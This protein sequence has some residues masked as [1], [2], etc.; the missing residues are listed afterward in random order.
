MK[1]LYIG[2]AGMMTNM[3]K[4]NVR[5]NNMANS[6]TS[7]FKFDQM[8]TTPI[9]KKTVMFQDN[10]SRRAIGT[11]EYAV[12]PEETYV[13][14]KPGSTY[15]TGRDQDFFIRDLDPDAGASF[16]VTELRGQ[17]YL[18]RGGQL[19][20]N[21]DGYLHTVEGAHL[22]DK[23]GAQIRVGVGTKLQVSA[24]G[25]IYNAETGAFLA[26]LAT[27]FVQTADKGR[28]VQFSGGKM[29]LE[30]MDT[31]ALP[32]GR[33]TIQNGV[34]EMS[35][36]DLGAQMVGLMED[37]RMV[38]ASSNVMAMFDKVYDKEATGLTRP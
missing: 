23:N 35:N 11:T 12:R 31:L 16:F 38:Q 37:Q 6:S 29:Q 27:K 19:H 30:G 10:A 24:D 18:S 21:A 25:R 2:A 33:G 34:L 26:Q 28:L 36:V 5:S 3:Q 32:D 4:I 1:G 20:V 22:L 14:L 13:N 7:G 15:I 8:T 17:T 9:S